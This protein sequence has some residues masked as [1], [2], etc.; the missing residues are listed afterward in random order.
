MLH[1]SPV[2]SVALITKRNNE[3]AENAG[4]EVLAWLE[5]R[6]VAV[7]VLSHG[8]VTEGAEVPQADLALVLGGDGSIVSVA[9][10]LLGRGIP[11]AGIN[12]GRVGFLAEL[13]PEN[14]QQG[15]SQ[16]FERGVLVEPRM[17]LRYELLRNASPV[18]GGEVINDVVLTRGNMA[19]LVPLNLGVDGV[20]LVSLRSDGLVMATPTGSTGYAGSAGGPLLATG[21][22]AY[23]VAAICPFLRVFQ[24]LVLEAESVLQVGLQAAG[25]EVFLTLDGQEVEEVLPGD[26]LQV[27]GVPNRFQVAGMG[28]SGYFEQLCKAG[29]VGR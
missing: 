19:R 25:V 9:R 13:T 23:V 7:T 12:F 8:A 27:Q 15:L 14:W 3:A 21:L 2:G 18:C 10:R 5:Q 4:R 28:L 17:T 6:K 26:T 22:N 11:V 29:F 24:P 20:P 1:S 16:A